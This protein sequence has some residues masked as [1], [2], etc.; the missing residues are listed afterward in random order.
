MNYGDRIVKNPHINIPS[1]SYD[2]D[3]YIMLSGSSTC[4]V[5]KYGDVVRKDIEG[6]EQL[7][8]I[9]GDFP[10]VD[11]EINGE[12]VTKR[13][14]ELVARE[15][16]IPIVGKTKIFHKNGNNQNC[17]C[18]NLMLTNDEEYN[19]LTDQLKRRK[20]S[21]I[22]VALHSRQK[23]S[24]FVDFN[25][26]K[27]AERWKAII[28]R[29]KQHQSYKDVKIC[30]QWLDKDTGLQAFSDWAWDAIYEYPSLLEV[31]KDVL[32]LG[33]NKAYSPKTS[34][35]LPKKFNLFMKCCD[36]KK[37]I[38]IKNSA[39]GTKYII[40]KNGKRKRIV[41]DSME[42]A[43]ARVLYRKAGMLRDMID[44]EIKLGFMPLKVL[45]ALQEWVE[46]WIMEAKEIEKQLELKKLEDE[47]DEA[48]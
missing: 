29:V 27:V 46:H 15:F 34:I 10:K 4:Y 26:V 35:F 20:Y 18:Y 3:T 30:K 16:L 2:H 12:T 7:P 5:S 8:I 31:D 14:D 40:P 9:E 44:E 33:Q 45:D 11:V 19:F 41:C 22:K 39:D 32:S 13:V 25:H 48:I 17:V 23:Y 37:S 42:E 21:S 24:Q 43:E 36:E 6:F 38:Q 1:C 47:E 28:Q